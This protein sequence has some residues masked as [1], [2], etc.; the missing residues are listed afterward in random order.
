MRKIQ[1]RLSFKP[2]RTENITPKYIIIINICG[3]WAQSAY[4]CP[5][6]ISKTIERGSFSKKKYIHKHIKKRPFS[7]SKGSA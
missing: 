3:M 2:L 5:S 6:E 4:L 7:I 1:V